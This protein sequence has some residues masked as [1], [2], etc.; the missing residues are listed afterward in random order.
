VKEGINLMKK[1]V[2]TISHPQQNQE[3]KHFFGR[4]CDLFMSPWTTK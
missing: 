1:A 3:Q 4:A 2:T